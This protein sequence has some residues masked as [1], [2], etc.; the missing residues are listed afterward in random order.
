MKAYCVSQ[1]LYIERTKSFDAYRS[2]PQN[3]ARLHLQPQKPFHPPC[4]AARTQRTPAKA[5]TLLSLRPSLRAPF[6]LQSKA[7][8]TRSPFHIFRSS[9]SPRSPATRKP[10]N[11][12][13]ISRSSTA[14][15]PNQYR[16]HAI[17]GVCGSR[18]IQRE[19]S[20]N[21]FRSRPGEP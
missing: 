9:R 4:Q 12:L 10:A 17:S 21:S 6:T 7:L 20:H 3:T 2:S 19:R 8:V 5:P 13:L 1:A 16:R 11:C 14:T 18:K 15:Q